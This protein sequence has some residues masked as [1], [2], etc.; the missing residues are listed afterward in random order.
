MYKTNDDKVHESYEDA[1]KLFEA[2]KKV[3]DD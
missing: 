3:L 1:F 2:I